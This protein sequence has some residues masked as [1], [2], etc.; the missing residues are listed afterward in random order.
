MEG[1]RN[2]ATAK[3]VKDMELTIDSRTFLSCPQEAL[4]SHNKHATPKNVKEC[5]GGEGGGG[6]RNHTAS[7][8]TSESK[9]K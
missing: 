1:R 9:L 8:F 3:N 2:Y 4:E 7:I 6:G 5:E